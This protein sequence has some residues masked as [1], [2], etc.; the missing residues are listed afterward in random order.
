MNDTDCKGKLILLDGLIERVILEF[1]FIDK[2]NIPSNLLDGIVNNQVI[3]FIGAGF[4]KNAIMPEGRTMPDWNEL[5]MVIASLMKDYQY[6]N[7]I[8]TFSFYEYSNSKSALIKQ[9]RGQLII[10]GMR[11]S[12][13]HKTLLKLFNNSLIFTTNYDT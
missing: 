9:L 13:V 4:S 3:P 8:D 11:P 7:A 1:N 2:Y 10:P 5:G 6:D 12:Q